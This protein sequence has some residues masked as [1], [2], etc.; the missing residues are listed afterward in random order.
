[1]LRLG[2]LTGLPVVLDGRIIGHVEQSI[3]CPDGAY[4]RGFAVRRGF[5]NAKWI[6]RTSVGVI[7][8]AAVIA[9]HQPGKMPKD[10]R[11]SFGA[12]FDADGLPLGRVTD[13]YISRHAMTVQALEI[14]LGPAETL[15]RGRY[16]V[17]RF[18]MAHVSGRPDAVIVPCGCILERPES[19][20]RR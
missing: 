8:D 3:L 20:V 16:I 6:P 7:G 2:R 14:S 10:C 11:F 5:G 17:R 15:R 12:V 9:L 13:V 1:M 4:L 19:E 18:T